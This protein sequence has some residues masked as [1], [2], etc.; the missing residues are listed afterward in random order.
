MMHWVSA[1][2]IMH[3]VSAILMMHWVSAMHHSNEALMLP[4]INIADWE[5]VRLVGK[6]ASHFQV[7]INVIK[8]QKC[9]FVLVTVPLLL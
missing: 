8:T 3:W 2:P 7:C 1:I 5:S 4:N 9:K 6:S